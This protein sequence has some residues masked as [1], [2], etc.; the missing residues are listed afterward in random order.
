MLNPAA[1]PA[2]L[3]PAPPRCP[4]RRPGQTPWPEHRQAGPGT[5]R[6]RASR[7]PKARP[8]PA[9]QGR[10]RPAGQRAHKGVPACRGQ[11]GTHGG[12]GPLPEKRTAPRGRYSCPRRACGHSRAGLPWRHHRPR[13]SRPQDTPP[14]AL[15]RGRR[16]TGPR[17]GL[18]RVAGTPPPAPG[19]HRAGRRPGHRRDRNPGA[20]VPARRAEVNGVGGHIPQHIA[21]PGVQHAPQRPAP[22]PMR[23]PDHDAHLPARRAWR[24][25]RRSPRYTPAGGAGA[26]AAGRGVRDPQ[27]VAAS[28][29]TAHGLPVPCRAEMPDPSA[30][31][32]APARQVARAERNDFA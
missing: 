16:I 25:P 20:G 32:A 6:A 29:W 2:G 11:A 13:R 28:S 23:T 15:R 7:A 8:D 26:L 12:R 9:R 1:W 31:Q 10:G 24:T 3:A 19:R 5:Q 4:H 22:T 21:A 30:S 27:L 14:V 17:R 18:V